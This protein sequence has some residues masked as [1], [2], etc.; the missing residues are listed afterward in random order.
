MSKIRFIGDVHGKVSVLIDM[1]N[2]M[3][4]DVTSVIQVG[5]MGVGFGQ[6]EHWHS[7]LD[8]A[9]KSKNARFIRGNHD[10]PNECEN[11][12][13]WIRDGHIENDMMFIGG[14]WSIDRHVRIEGI[15]W[16]VNEE[17]SYGEL[18]RMVDVYSH[19]LPNVM[20]THDCPRVAATK[21]FFD[22]GRPL[23]GKEQKGTRTSYALDSM[24]E[25]HKPKIHVFGH[26][27][28][29]VDEVIDGTR[30][31]CLNELSYVDV[32]VQTYEVVRTN[33]FQY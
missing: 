3:P 9:L 30:F 33:Q 31:I 21:F 11:M 15:N 32:D 27:H 18:G 23:Y 29:D 12:E 4:E 24:F 7:R 10:D 8:E 22:V 13:S 1:L 2:D 6:S 28:Y 14:A 20:V 17:L 25:I 16:W 19:V 5:D 26:W